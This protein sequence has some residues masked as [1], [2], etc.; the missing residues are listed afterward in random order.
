MAG[1]GR[2]GRPSI[3]AGA[4]GQRPERRR[5]PRRCVG[6]GDRGAAVGARFQ[7]RAAGGA[8]R[9][10]GDRAGPRVRRGGASPGGHHR[11]HGPDPARRDA[12]GDGA[13]CSTTRCRASPRPCAPRAAAR[14]RSPPCPAAWSACAAAAWSSTCRVAARGAR[15]RSRSSCRCSTTRSRRCRGRS[16]TPRRAPAAARPAAGDLPAGDDPGD[17]RRAEVFPAFADVPGYPLVFPLFWGAA[18]FFVLAMARHLRVFAAAR[19]ASPTD[20][21]GAR[22]CGHAPLRH[23]P[24]ADVPRHARP[25]SCTRASSGASCCS[26]SAPRT[27]SPAA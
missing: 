18:A 13:P 1:P 7:R 6:G 27:S 19:N 20:H 3:G 22:L 5:D 15:S 11:R 14:R 17:R 4:D 10:V 9:A 12:A 25:G 2:A 16:I 23:R 8:R 21:V 26:R 24:D